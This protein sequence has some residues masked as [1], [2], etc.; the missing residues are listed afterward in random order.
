MK[1]KSHCGSNSSDW[2]PIFVDETHF[3]CIPTLWGATLIFPSTTLR[4]I[5]FDSVQYILFWWSLTH[6]KLVYTLILLLIP[7]GTTLKW[8]WDCQKLHCQ[9][10]LVSVQKF[11]HIPFSSFVSEFLSTFRFSS[12]KKNTI[13]VLPE[14]DCFFFPG[15]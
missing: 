9:F 3:S 4:D 5:A 8:H 6:S 14:R 15:S 13:F 2:S 1:L 7:L 10:A 12:V 11:G